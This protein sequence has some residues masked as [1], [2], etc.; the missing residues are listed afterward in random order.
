LKT[1]TKKMPAKVASGG[2]K[3]TGSKR[4]HK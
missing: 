1:F 2:K 4:T 3:Y